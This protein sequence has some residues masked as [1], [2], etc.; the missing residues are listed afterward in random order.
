[1]D[2]KKKRKYTN[3]NHLSLGLLTRKGFTCEVVEKWIPYANIRKDMFGLIDIVG[4]RKELMIGVQS[5]TLHNKLEHIK[6]AL[7]SP[8]LYKWLA[9]NSMFVIMSWEKDGSRWKVNVHNITVHPVEQSYIQTDL[10]D[11]FLGIPDSEE[12]LD[13]KN[14]KK[15]ANPDISSNVTEG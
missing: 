5:T 6:K 13:K 14:A 15:E 8:N 3:Y 7:A 11:W 4:I 9:T 2:E 1:M 10:T 12:Y